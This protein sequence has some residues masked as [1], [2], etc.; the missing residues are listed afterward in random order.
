MSDVDTGLVLSGDPRDVLTVAARK[1]GVSTAEATLIR[2][3]TNV[4]YEMADGVVARVG[5]P[6]SQL[7]VVP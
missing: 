3:G 5:P 6:G 4:I 1:A 7:K 2:D